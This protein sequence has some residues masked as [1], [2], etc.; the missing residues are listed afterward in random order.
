[1]Y[2]REVADLFR[3]YVD[4]KDLTFMDA[5]KVAVF[6]KL[7]YSDFRQ[8]AA[9]ADP[10]FYETQ[11]TLALTNATEYDFALAGN[12]VRLL[13]NP[14]G[15]LTGPR[16]ERIVELV[17]PSAGWPVYPRV[18]YGVRSLA[19]LSSPESCYFFAGTKLKFPAAVNATFAMRYIGTE[20]IDWTKQ[21]AID[22]EVIDD[23]VE[24]HDLISLMAA[25]QYAIVDAAFNAQLQARLTFR[26]E[27]FKEFLSVGR[28][29]SASTR[30]NLTY[31]P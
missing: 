8:M 12:P 6:L 26:T 5:A 4:E 13:G 2:V 3:H 7:G 14:V 15:G 22:N 10:T 23:N 20:A 24:W 21:A 28:D 11:V 25:Q 27:A 17:E 31:D 19:Q 30:V 1:M 9:Q 16:L 18:W 29:L